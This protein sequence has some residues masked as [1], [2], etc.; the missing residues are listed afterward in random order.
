MNRLMFIAFIVFGLTCYS[1]NPSH[2]IL[3]SIRIANKSKRIIYQTSE[4]EKY[5]DLLKS[6]F[7]NIIPK[8]SVA[9][10]KLPFAISDRSDFKKV[11]IIS[12]FGVYRKSN[13]K[14]HKHSGI[15]IVP[16]LKDKYIHV[17]PV[18]NGVVCFVRIDPPF[19]TVVIKHKLK[20]NSYIYTSYIHL[21]EIYIQKGQQVDQN[22]D[23]GKLFTYEEA[24]KYNGP[25]DHLHLEI[26]KSFDDYSCA[27]Y[28]CM[29]L[30]KLEEFFYDPFIFLRDNL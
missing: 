23:I 12:S 7:I 2:G 18:A 3:D 30:Q 6:D 17:F 19:S 24:W 26:R 5:R 28:L 13:Y 29:S 8:D 4:I 22:T 9:S 10:W 15:D 14:G 11:K 16:L 1:N 25:Y 27:T 21:K 20:G